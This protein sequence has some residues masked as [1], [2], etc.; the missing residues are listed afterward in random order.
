MPERAYL[1]IHV[2]ESLRQGLD[3]SRPEGRP[4]SA[5]AASLGPGV[6]GRGSGERPS[7]DRLRMLERIGRAAL[8]PALSR[9]ERGPRVLILELGSLP[10]AYPF[11]H[12]PSGCCLGISGQVES[13]GKG[14]RY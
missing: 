14:E 9:G 12:S 13:N 7:F 5:S 4:A 1:S 3:L 11:L 6:R 2:D 10:N 8:T